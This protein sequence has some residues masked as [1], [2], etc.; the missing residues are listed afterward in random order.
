LALNVKLQT[1]TAPLT[2]VSTHCWAGVVA[3]LMVKVTV[4]EG[5]ACPTNGV[6]GYLGITVAVKATVWVTADEAG[7]E[8]TVVVV[9]DRFTTCVALGVF[10]AE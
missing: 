10:P 7:E 4:P 2:I 8:T 6:V 1:G 3:G 5:T 9:G